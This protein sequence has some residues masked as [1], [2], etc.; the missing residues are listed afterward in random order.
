MKSI[1]HQNNQKGIILLTVLMMIMVISVLAISILNMNLGQVL[2]SEE[3]AK[4]IKATIIAKGMVNYVHANQF[5]VP[6][7]PIVLTVT[8]IL[9]SIT[10]TTT[11]TLDGGNIGL[12]DT[13]LLN[14]DTNY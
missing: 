4:Q 6:S 10:Y 3:Q 9:D 7:T 14:I 12:N 13:N 2:T 11:A 1:M 5:A 8:D